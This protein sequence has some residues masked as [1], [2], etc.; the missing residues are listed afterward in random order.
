MAH[1]IGVAE[2]SGSEEDLLLAEREGKEKRGLFSLPKDIL[3]K[4]GMERR[5]VRRVIGG[6]FQSRRPKT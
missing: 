6:T 3:Q 1:P 2:M 4:F 5:R